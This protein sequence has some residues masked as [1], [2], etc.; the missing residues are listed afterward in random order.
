MSISPVPQRSGFPRAAP[1]QD[2]HRRVVETRKRIRADG[3]RQMMIDETEASF[4]WAEQLPKPVLTAFLVP[5]AHKLARRIEQSARIHRLLA[6]RVA[7]QI[8]QKTGSWRRPSLAD[9][10]DF[11]GPDS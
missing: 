3:V 5:H 4:R 7:P 9:K 1:I 8:V 2:K 6:R 10:I 11:V